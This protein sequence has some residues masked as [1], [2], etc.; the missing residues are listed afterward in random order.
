MPAAVQEGLLGGYRCERNPNRIPRLRLPAAPVH[1]R[2]DT[3]YATVEPEGE[4]YVTVQGQQFVPGDRGRILL[5]L[6]SAASAARSITRVRSVLDPVS[7][8]RIYIPRR[9]NDFRMRTGP[10]LDSCTSIR[11]VPG[12]PIRVTSSAESPTTGSRS[13]GD[14]HVSGRHAARIYPARSGSARAR[15]VADG[16]NC[17]YLPGPFRFCL[18]C[19]VSY[20]FRM[21]TDFGK[22]ATL[23]SEGRSTATTVL[24]LTAIRSLRREESL[25]PRA[26]KLLSF[27]DNRQDASLQAGHFNRLRGDQPVAVGAL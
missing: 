19:G 9:L 5:P 4:R 3:A 24:G 15:E 16:L 11:S 2:G 8:L 21:S 14:R 22:L 18:H 23:T 26:R 17:H 20:G 12:R 27:T 7:G 1:S 6:C 13:T 10:R 25:P